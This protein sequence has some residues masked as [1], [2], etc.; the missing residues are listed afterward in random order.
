MEINRNVVEAV[1]N[2]NAGVVSIEKG[3]NNGTR[4][5]IIIIN[6]SPAAQVISLS[7]D[8]EAKAGEGIVLNAGGSWQD[9]RD[10][11]YWPTQ[12]LISAISSAA[13][14]TLA[15]QERLV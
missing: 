13:G 2:A 7:I 12:K 5:S 15:I 14:G 3:N 9:S 4:S 1:T 8:A 10:G 6:T 11:N